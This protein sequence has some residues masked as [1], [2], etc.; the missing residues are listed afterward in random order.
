VP[1]ALERRRVEQA[2]GLIQAEAPRA[3]IVL[4]TVFAGRS[5]RGAARTDRAIVAAARAA[6]SAVIII[7]P[8]AAEWRYAHVRDGLH[9]TA[10]GSA[11][12][13]GRVAASLREYGVHP[14]PTGAR[15]RA[16][17]CDS[18]TASLRRRSGQSSGRHRTGGR[19]QAE[20]NQRP[21]P[22]RL[23]GLDRSAVACGHLPDN[24]QP[25][26]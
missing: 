6:D 19:D 25:Q 4:L 24:G 21:A 1:P 8:L 18:A 12:I 23:L 16:I 22:G 15:R 20:T 17:I 13:A 3:Q 14:A 5:P 7:D 10:A 11:W 2:V 9:P 26:A